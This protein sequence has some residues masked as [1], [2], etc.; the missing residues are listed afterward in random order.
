MAEYWYKL[1][2]EWV[3]VQKRSGL[4]IPYIIGA[5]EL[6]GNSSQESVESLINN[7]V[8]SDYGKTIVLKR[9][10]DLN[11]YI[12]T[13]ERAI[14]YP[15]NFIHRSPQSGN[16][17]FKAALDTKPLGDNIAEIIRKLAK[18]YENN[19]NKGQFSRDMFLSWTEYSENEKEFIIQVLK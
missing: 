9:C 14:I 18:R 7:I 4:T 10:D 16:I 6:T 15:E 2:Q 13:I 11:E 3:I 1:L 8:K 17:I 12:L 19:I 5:L